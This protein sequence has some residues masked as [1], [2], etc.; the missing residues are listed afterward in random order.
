M[1]LEG[2]SI[3]EDYSV[4]MSVYYKEQPQYLKDSIQS[5]IDQTVTSNDF[6]LVC[7]GKLSDELNE[8][9]DLFNTEYQGE[10]NVIRLPEN[11]GQGYALNV[12]LSHCK[13][14][15]IAR[16]D[17]DDIAYP[18]RCELQL[19]CFNNDVDIVSAAVEEFLNDINNIVATRVLP[20]THEEIL[21]F[22]KRRNPFNHP[23][24]MFRKEAVLKAGNYQDFYLYE[25]Y[26]LWMR[27]LKIGAIGYNIQLPLLYMRAGKDMYK[28]RGGY[29]YFISSRN[30][31]KFLLDNRIIGFGRYTYNVILRFLAQVIVGDSIRGFFFRLFMRSK[32]RQYTCI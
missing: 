18:S 13:N 26:Y 2:E 32:F 30:F 10:F 3:L 8:V 27:M 14:S 31:Q 22:S 6:V 17:S 24:V 11:R 12:G 15:L 21:K 5:M 23:C 20:E 29:K 1:Y 9:I 19:K 16:M 7:D 25:D 28:R 4:L